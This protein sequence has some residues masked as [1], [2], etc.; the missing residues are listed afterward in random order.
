[1]RQNKDSPYNFK[2]AVQ[3]VRYDGCV[4]RMPAD[5]RF[6]ACLAG[7]GGIENLLTV[8][9]QIELPVSGEAIL[10]LAHIPAGRQH[11]GGCM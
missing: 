7:V 8:L 2:S 10:L 11:L 1:M 4:L 5:R 9:E 3:A 6:N